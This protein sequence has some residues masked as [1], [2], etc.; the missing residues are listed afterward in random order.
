MKVILF[1]GPPRSGKDS[2][3]L[4]TEGFVFDQPNTGMV[5]HEK[6]SRPLKAAFA[7]MMN[8]TMNEDFNVGFY[9]E[10]KEEVIPCLGV[11]FRQWQIDFSEK[12]M[13]P[14]Y[15]ND[16]FGR[17]LWDRLAGQIEE[18]EGKPAFVV[19]SDCG[20]QVE[21]DYLLKKLPPENIFLF[22]LQRH[23]TSYVG[24]SRGYIYA[25]ESVLQCEFYNDGPLADMQERVCKAIKEWARL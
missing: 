21:V 16:V 2:L 3:S 10:H 12:F 11:S 15:G 1:N 20:F 25:P 13:K 17:L 23:G 5:V 7:A 6:F 14:L 19:I 9:E 24:D 22:R 4:A 18:V 8:E